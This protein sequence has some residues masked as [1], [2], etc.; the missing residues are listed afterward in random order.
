MRNPMASQTE[1]RGDTKLA[2]IEMRKELARRIA[3]HAPSAGEH[4]TAI[5]G[6]C[7]FRRTSP[8]PCRRGAYE[9]SLNV[10]AQGKSASISGEPRTSAMDRHFC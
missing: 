2:R 8:T 7:L 1:K 6:L 4:P 5:P 10:F 9:P 3:G